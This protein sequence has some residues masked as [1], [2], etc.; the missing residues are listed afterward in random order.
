MIPAAFDYVVPRTLPE[1]VA[2]LSSTA[3]KARSS[4]AATASSP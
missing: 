2:E 3:R 1:A 4:R